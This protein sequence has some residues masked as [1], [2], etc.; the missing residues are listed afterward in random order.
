M[1][2]QSYRLD[3]GIKHRPDTRRVANLIVSLAGRQNLI[4][5]CLKSVMYHHKKTRGRRRRALGKTS[6]RLLKIGRPSGNP[7]S[8]IG[9]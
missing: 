6:Y 3:S 1:S 4:E 7:D 8:G 9:V 5:I 2:K